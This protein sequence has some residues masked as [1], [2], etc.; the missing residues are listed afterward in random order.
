[1]RVLRVGPW[2]PTRFRNATI[3]SVEPSSTNFAM[4]TLNTGRFS[5]VIRVHSGLWRSLANLVVVAQSPDEGRDVGAWGNQV[6]EADEVT[7]EMFGFWDFGF[8]VSGL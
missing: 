3:V 7:Y 1:M 6:I 8:R 4:L 5:N 2:L